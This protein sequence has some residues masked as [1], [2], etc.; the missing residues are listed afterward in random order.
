MIYFIFS[1]VFILSGVG[2][3]VLQVAACT[4]VKKAYGIEKAETPARYAEALHSQFVR[5]MAWYGKT[6]AHVELEKGDFLCDTVKD[7]ISSAE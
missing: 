5:W 6:H 3:V 7:K 4:S 1:A 2:Q